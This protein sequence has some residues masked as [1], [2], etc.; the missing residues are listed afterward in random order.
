MTAGLANTV[1]AGIFSVMNCEK[2]ND[3]TRTDT[4]ERGLVSA[5][6]LKNSA[7]E[8][9]EL[10]QGSSGK[11]AKVLNS[12]SDT[13]KSIRNSS[14]VFDY[15][16][17]GV[18][19]LSE[20]I[21]PLLVVASGVRVYNSDDKKSA[22]IKE[23]GAMSCMF[24]AEGAAKKLFGLNKGAEATYKKYK[25]LKNAAEGIK[26]FCSSNK[27]LSK[28]P[29]G[30]IGGIIKGIAFIAASCTG[31]SIGGYV[32]EKIADKT[33]AKTYAEKHALETETA[34]KDSTKEFVS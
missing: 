15:A 34:G 11:T 12:A 25:V 14:K 31:F 8:A 9:L 30:K 28:V 22:L 33:T 16:C 6:Q 7:G 26:N 27:I 19:V 24:A 2:A 23:T 29:S 5:L 3:I 21:N 10:A 20:Y 17:K 18:N 1:R 32:G 13:I 4:R